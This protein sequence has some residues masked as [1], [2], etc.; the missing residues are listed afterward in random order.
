MANAG[1]G[2]GEI[3]EA[4]QA[5]DHPAGLLIHDPLGAEAPAAA[6]RQPGIAAGHQVVEDP[7]G[8]QLHGSIGHG[9]ERCLIGTKQGGADQGGQLLQHT[10]LGV[11]ALA[12]H[13]RFA[14]GKPPELIEPPHA[15]GGAE[16]GGPAD[17]TEQAVDRGMHPPQHPGPMVEA[18]VT[19]D[20]QPE[21]IAQQQ[22]LGKGHGL[23]SEI[24]GR[25][26]C[27]SE[28]ASPDR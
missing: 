26:S 27:G 3:I 16:R 2:Q 4:L 24:W 7:A 9:A 5:R 28:P 23:E 15:T 10:G 14:L 18:L 13:E 20:P 11:G 21:Q 12:F 17:P 1:A 19:A 25:L 6:A 22:L 8:S